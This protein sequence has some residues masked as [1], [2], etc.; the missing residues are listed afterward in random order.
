MWKVLGLLAV[1]LAG[2]AGVALY[3]NGGSDAEVLPSPADATQFSDLK[4]SLVALDRRV[5]L[6]TSEVEALRE[7]RGRQGAAGQGRTDDADIAERMAARPEI[8]DEMR[9]RFAER[10]GNPPDMAELR[11]R[12]QQR[13]LDR[14]V[15]AG[16]T[17]ERAQW[18][19]RRTE[20]LRVAQMEAEFEAQ[21]SGQNVQA[22]DPDQA[23]R[24]EI[25]DSEYERYL[26]AS[27]RPTEVRVMEVLATSSA[28]RSGIKAGDEILAYNGTRV[29]ETRELNAL[30]MGG[31]PGQ[32]VTVEV[33]RNGQT[34]Q[35]SVPSGP[36]GVSAGGRQGGGPGGGGGPP[37]GFR[38]GGRGGG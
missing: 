25:G 10:N 31:T 8:T 20:E 9:Q 12:Q 17:P 21:R 4:E 1:G 6:L 22:I 34:L 19:A 33:R 2:G 36:L 5:R 28:E 29:F 15:Q 27:G 26:K 13:E 24:K 37:G 11:V 18:I 32:T 7:A 38:P 30:T 35:V 23:L 3:L 14:L 16:F